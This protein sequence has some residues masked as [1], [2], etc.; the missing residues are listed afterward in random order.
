MK[1]LSFV[2]QIARTRQ[3]RARL[4]FFRRERELLNDD[5][6]TARPNCATVNAPRCPEG[7]KQLAAG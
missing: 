4:M 5:T 6:E 2:P 7:R 3:L 1:P